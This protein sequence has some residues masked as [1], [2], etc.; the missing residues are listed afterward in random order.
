VDAATSTDEGQWHRLGVLETRATTSEHPSIGGQDCH[1]SGRLKNDSV[2]VAARLCPVEPRLLAAARNN[3]IEVRIS[4]HAVDG[5]GIAGADRVLVASW[6]F[7]DDGDGT[8]GT[9][10]YR[11]RRIERRRAGEVDH[12]AGVLALSLPCH[13]G[14][15]RDA[16]RR[17][18]FREVRNVGSHGGVV[19]AACALDFQNAGRTARPTGICRGTELFGMGICANRRLGF[20]I[21]RGNVAVHQQ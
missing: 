1:F 18:V 5:A 13:A 9:S 21:I 6:R 14:A 10:H 19:P 4:A 12:D 17:R 2:A 11:S 20:L 7:C 3:Q 8:I 15:R 16:N